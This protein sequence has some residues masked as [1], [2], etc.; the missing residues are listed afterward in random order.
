MAQS[1]ILGLDVGGANLKAA[2]T[3]GRA[4]TIPFA[5]WKQPERLPAA[6]A[7]LVA[8]FP[9]AAEFAVTMTG[10]LCDCYETK[11]QGVSAIL[12]AV[13][14]AAG[15][16]RV[17]I[18][19]VVEEFVTVARARA[20]HVGVAA[21]N[22]HALATFAGRF[23]PRYGGMLIDIGSTTSDLIPL[24][25]G[26]PHTQGWDDYGRLESREL[27]YAGVR[28][29]PICALIPEQTAAELFA[30][31]RD[32]YLILGLVP[33]KPDDT[34]TADGRPASVEYALTRLARML[35]TDREIMT[36]DGIISFAIT[37]HERLRERLTT[38]ARDVFYAGMPPELRTVIVSGE[39][40]FLARQVAERAFGDAPVERIVS[41]ND[42][43]GPTV[44]A[45]APA[46]A[47]AVLASER[48]S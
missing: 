25:D 18:W 14:A 11:R 16:R 30:T 13:E 26:M 32:V 46:Y 8:K 19:S 33:E 38:A 35:G 15:S 1:T 9:D 21:S 28:R 42:E 45:C 48:R 39:G 27:V 12:D 6:L 36:D 29:T 37:V 24:S 7:E 47:L 43:L 31:T 3:D 40:E 17:C 44:S 41:L 4:V 2:T 23:A 5:L 34:E 10:E 20:N 22:W